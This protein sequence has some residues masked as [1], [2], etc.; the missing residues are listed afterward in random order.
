MI[1]NVS[2]DSFI[3][4]PVSKSLIRTKLILYLWIAQR[5]LNALEI[6]RTQRDSIPPFR[7][8]DEKEG[9]E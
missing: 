6:R 1:S 7:I 9:G 8:E 4:T 5:N 2:Y 3:V